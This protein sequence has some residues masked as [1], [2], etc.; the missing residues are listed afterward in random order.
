MSSCFERADDPRPPIDD[1]LKIRCHHVPRDFLSCPYPRS[2]SVVFPVIGRIMTDIPLI[3]NGS[4]SI[5]PKGADMFSA[6][7][8]TAGSPRSDPRDSG[9]SPRGYAACQRDAPDRLPRRRYVP[10]STA[11]CAWPELRP[12]VEPREP[13]CHLRRD[14]APLP[15]HFIRGLCARPRRSPSSDGA[16]VV[17]HEVPPGSISPGCVGAMALCPVECDRHVTPP[18][19]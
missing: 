3:I 8:S 4:D 16:L 15:E 1:C 18:Q 10:R 13:E 12:I 19:W 5:L 11:R 14:C 9:R 7:A 6:D 17:R 2:V